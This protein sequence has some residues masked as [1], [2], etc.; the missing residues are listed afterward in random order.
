[1]P[2]LTRTFIQSD[3]TIY[4]C[5]K[6]NNGKSYYSIG[7][8]INGYDYTKLTKLINMYRKIGSRCA[9]CWAINKCKKCWTTITEDDCEVQKRKVINSLVSSMEVYENFP[10]AIENL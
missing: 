7:D 6:V 5:E 4:L 2:G 10:L 9:S 1:M 3:G 8:I